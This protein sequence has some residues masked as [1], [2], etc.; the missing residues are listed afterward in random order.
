MNKKLWNEFLNGKLAINCRT[1]NQAKKFLKYCE[2][3]GLKWDSGDLI[4]SKTY[5]SVYNESTCYLY[6]FNPFMLLVITQKELFERNGFKIISFK[7]LTKTDE[8]PIEDKQYRGWEILKM[9]KEGAKD[10]YFEN[11]SGIDCFI[12]EYGGLRYADGDSNIG[13]DY[14]LT[15][16]FTIKEKQC[17]TFDEARKLGKPHHKE[18]KYNCCSFTLEEFIREIDKK[19]WE[20]KQ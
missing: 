14:L 4:T 20:V 13:I 15:Y 16:T 11:N 3:Q 17:L 1:E 8:E 6:K 5:W 9:I 19:V 12:D 18:E 2:E 7:E 10:I